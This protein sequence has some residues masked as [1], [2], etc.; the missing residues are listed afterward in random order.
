[1]TRIIRNRCVLGRNDIASKVIKS[2][3]DLE[4][5]SNGR[6]PKE[7]ELKDVS[8]EFQIQANT[9]GRTMESL[10][11]MVVEAEEM[12]QRFFRQARA[13]P[14]EPREVWTNFD[15]RPA[16]APQVAL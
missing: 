5:H 9:G 4:Q 3:F 10:S 8:K 11:R 2:K 1:M 12:G 14:V 16:E 13:A 7:A 15:R 6:A